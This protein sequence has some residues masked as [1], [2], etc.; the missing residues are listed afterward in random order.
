ML[1]Q[2]LLHVVLVLWMSKIVPSKI[3]PPWQLLQVLET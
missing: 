3:V 1:C 2:C